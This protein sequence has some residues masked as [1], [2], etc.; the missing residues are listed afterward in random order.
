MDIDRP[1][2]QQ[3]AAVGATLDAP[4][5]GIAQ[6]PKIR[7]AIAANKIAGIRLL[8]AA[9][10]KPTPQDTEMD[11]DYPPPEIDQLATSVDSVPHPEPAPTAAAQAPTAT[12]EASEATASLEHTSTTST[13]AHASRLALLAA[14]AHRLR[15]PRRRTIPLQPPVGRLLIL[16]AGKA[17]NPKPD[18]RLRLSEL[19]PKNY[20][21]F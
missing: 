7:T 8:H 4:R 13:P 16:S 9:R 3:K 5:G 6:T 18:A 21:H 20:K 17:P 12:R 15:R 2:E 19:Q 10:P 1:E 11:D 14:E